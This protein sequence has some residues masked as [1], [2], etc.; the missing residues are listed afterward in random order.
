MQIYKTIVTGKDHIIP[1]NGFEAGFLVKP[2][3]NVFI[4]KR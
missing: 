2:L 4:L 3:I 1:S